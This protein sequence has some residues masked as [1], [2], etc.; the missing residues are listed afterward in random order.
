MIAGF[1]FLLII[2]GGYVSNVELPDADKQ[3]SNGTITG[4]NKD[5]EE[6]V[7]NFQDIVNH[8][9]LKKDEFKYTMSRPIIN[10][11]DYT[12][13]FVTTR[14]YAIL[15]MAWRNEYINWKP[16]DFCGI[17]YITIPTSYLWIPDI[18][19]EEMTEK[20]K[21]SPSPYLSIYHNGSVEFRND[22]VVQST[23]KMHVYKFPFDTQ[24]CNLSFKSIF[25]DD[26]EIYLR[27]KS[28]NNSTVTE[29]SRK[30][31]HTQYEWLFIDMSVNN[32]IV[33]DYGFNQTV[34]IYTIT[35]KRRSV[36][37]VANF[38]LPVLFFLLLDLSSFLISDTGGEKLGFKVTVLL[39]VTVMQLLLNEIL[40]SSSDS[41]PLIAVYCIGI[42]ALMLL[43][44]LEA[45]LVKHLIEKD[46]AVEDETDGDRSLGEN[47]G[48]NQGSHNFYSCFRAFTHILKSVAEQILKFCMW[49]RTID[50][51]TFY[52]QFQK[53]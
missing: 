18:T 41:I 40:P 24:S 42:F 45:I 23:C 37:Y 21:A 51:D 39:A 43:S 8:L 48:N 2:T 53:C 26:K 49:L 13:V 46:S 7:C 5:E 22:Q 38:L 6:K 32:E 10:N 29:L 11:K 19:I 12:E 52:N 3:K 14:L 36:L 17:E 44:L 35:M 1:F 20:D 50:M 15:D 34:V 28:I 47:S 33:E 9:N 27:N 4:D 25:H 16:E 30:M 31:M